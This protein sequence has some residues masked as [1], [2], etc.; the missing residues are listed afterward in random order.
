MCFDFWG[1]FA[2]KLI[3]VFR[4]K[5]IIQLVRYQRSMEIRIFCQEEAKQHDLRA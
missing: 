3:I 5:T 4:D 2:K 1:K